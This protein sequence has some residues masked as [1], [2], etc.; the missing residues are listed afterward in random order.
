MNTF[1][2]NDVVTKKYG[3]KTARIISLP[4]NPNAGLYNWAAQ[5]MCR[6]ISSGTTFRAHA[7]ELKLASDNSSQSPLANMKT[8]YSFTKSDGT[9]GY[10][11]YLA[12]NS[13]SQMILEEKGTGAVLTFEKDQLEEVLPYTFAVKINGKETHYMGDANSTLKKGDVVML[14]DPG[15]NFMIGVVS[16]VDTKNRAPREKFKGVK[17]V[18][19]AI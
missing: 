14:T 12:T 16:G 3:K 2:I 4:T 6:Y 9:T 5:Y 8:L 7:Q 10:G 1:N 13:A 17:L 11:T 15:S 18:T 19:E